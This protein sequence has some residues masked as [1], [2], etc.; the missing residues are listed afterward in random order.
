[1]PKNLNFMYKKYP[2]I[3]TITGLLCLFITTSLQAQTATKTTTDS[4][5]IKRAQSVYVELFGPG[6]ILSGN[7]DI[8]FKKTR[9]GLGA[10]IGVGYIKEK[11]S[12]M[13]SFPVQVNYL[14]G[15]GNKFFEIGAG[16]SYLNITHSDKSISSDY[17]GFGDGPMLLGTITFGY[18]YEPREGGFTFRASVNPLFNSEMFTP[19][20][21][22]SLG[23]SF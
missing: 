13:T 11:E 19:S 23:Y 15:K 2:L 22:I 21:G 10:R 12:T 1:M 16:A 8:R 6:L 18:R 17:L 20:G 14:L 7:Y 4:T 3:T 9:D 5:V